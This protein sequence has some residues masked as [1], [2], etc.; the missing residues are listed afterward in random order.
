MLER[1]KIIQ[2]ALLRLGNITSYNDDRSRIYKSC[3]DIIENVISNVCSESSLNFQ[4]T[5]VTLT[6]YSVE[7]NG[8]YRYNLPI[9]FLS[10]CIR[11]KKIRSVTGRINSP[12]KDMLYPRKVYTRVQ[13]EY[14]YSNSNKLE[15]HYARKISLNEFP[16]YLK[17]VLI[18]RLACEI[19]LVNPAFVERLPYCEMKANEEL[20]KVQVR[21]GMGEIYE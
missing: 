16:E 6:E 10:I 17:E 1:G 21:E 2:M 9:D 15:L 5:N 8:E 20:V 7:A 4:T 18:W 13:G 14:I 3:E 11:P 19:A 12:L